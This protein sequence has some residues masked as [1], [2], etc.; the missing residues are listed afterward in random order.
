VLAFASPYSETPGETIGR[1]A[2]DALDVPA[3]DQQV[4]IF[5]EQG[6]V[7]R[8]DYYWEKHHTVGEFDGELK[9]AGDGIRDGVLLHEKE[10][11]DRLREAGIEVFRIG[12]R[13]SP[14]Q[15]ASVRRKAFAAFD[16]A[17]RSTA[18]RT[19]RFKRQPPRE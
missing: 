19:Y 11:E 17:A 12:W 6:F 2:F 3:P 5:D 4:L 8:C 13:E 1:I 10:R 16:R 9:Y 18:R 7:G 15:S 14:A